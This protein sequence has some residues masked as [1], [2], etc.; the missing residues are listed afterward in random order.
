MKEN[1]S[2]N[3]GAQRIEPQNDF[4]CHDTDMERQ[5]AMHSYLHLHVKA[6][7]LAKYTTLRG[8]LAKEDSK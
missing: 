3:S 2:D 4:Q 8:F 5:I 1:T 6:R 7:Q